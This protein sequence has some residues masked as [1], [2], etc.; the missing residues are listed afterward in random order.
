MGVKLRSSNEECICQFSIRSNSLRLHRTVSTLCCRNVSVFTPFSSA[1]SQTYLSKYICERMGSRSLHYSEFHASAAPNYTNSL[2]LK[3]TSDMFTSATC[4]EYRLWHLTG[5][6][7]LSARHFVIVR[8][9]KMSDV[10]KNMCMKSVTTDTLF[11][12][13]SY[14][15]PLTLWRLDLNLL[16]YK[17]SVRTA[18]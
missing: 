8:S 10:I 17:D 9:I 6:E 15:W 7:P 13:D 18:Q 1:F 11:W 16:L 3:Q 12:P 2:P 5:V 4:E 14:D